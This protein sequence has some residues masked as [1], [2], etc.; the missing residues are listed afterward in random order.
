MKFTAAFLFGAGLVNAAL[1]NFPSEWNAQVDSTV[2]LFQ[3]GTHNDTSETACCDLEASQCKIQTE[4]LALLQYSD[5]ANNRSVEIVGAQA[6]FDFY[7]IGKQVSAQSDGKGGWT[8]Q[9][10]CPLQGDFFDPLVFDASAQDLG[11]ATL[12]GK[13]YEHY[14]WF[15]ELFKRVKMDQ[16]DWYVDTS[17]AKPVP[18]KNVEKLTPFG[19][20]EIALSTAA[21]A[22]FAQ[23]VDSKVFNVAGL[24]SCDQGDNCQQNED[25]RAR[26]ERRINFLRGR[27][28]IAQRAKRLGM[29]SSTPAP[30]APASPEALS[31]PSAASWPNE[32]S[33]FESQSLVIN[34]GGAPSADGRSVCCQVHTMSQCQVQE[35]YQAG[36]KYYDYTNK[37]TRFEDGGSG[38]IFVDLY[39]VHKSLQV[40]HNG[41]HDVCQSYCP[42]DPDDTLDKGKYAFLDPNATDL[43]KATY[44]GQAA[45]HWQWKDKIL[46]V[47]T[48]QTSDFY[49]STTGSSVVPLG[50]VDQLTPFGQHLGDS[51]VGWDKF[52]AGTP[53]AAKF[54][55]QGVDSC[56]QNPQCGQQSRQLHRLAN[57]QLNTYARYAAAPFAN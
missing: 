9:S 3:G 47:I 12:D 16:Q 51:T 4:G 13:T 19:G 38:Q 21:Y 24:D 42:I 29:A 37:R 34:Q 17:G 32:W 54:D 39:D 18:F 44:K 8:C 53:P 33:A 49:A 50:R 11:N 45:E 23:G 41:T 30:E 22:Q 55:V 46:G 35:Q 20:A 56:P 28:T 14:Q 40:V 1:P 52:T 48:M 31:S 2:M 5:R 26:L 43:G 25:P 7:A 15:D 27:E 36:Q 57:R 6:I 10:Y